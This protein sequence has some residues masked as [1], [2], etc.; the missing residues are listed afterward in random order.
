MV[1]EMA[2]F[3]Q[4]IM[5]IDAA[6]V[7]C[8]SSARAGTSCFSRPA[9]PRLPDGDSYHDPVF[10]DESR[11]RLFL[12]QWFETE[13]LKATMSASGII[14]GSLQGVDDF[15]PKGTAVVRIVLLL[16]P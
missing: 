16:H 6:G 12:D 13:V 9:V 15:F 11:E 8:R 5:N 3:G 2:R 1:F 7:R 10:D 4:T 14:W